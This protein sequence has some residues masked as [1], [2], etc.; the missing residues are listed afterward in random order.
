MKMKHMGKKTAALVLALG[1]TF[2][3]TGCEFFVA[4]NVRDLEQVV[5]TVDISN[6]LATD[7]Q[8]VAA[9]LDTLIADGA[10]STD[11][12]KRELVSL[13]LNS[14]YSYVQQGYSYKDVFNLLMDSLTGRKILALYNPPKRKCL[15]RI[16]KRKNLRK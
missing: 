16:I 6:E 11:I 13:F 3:A 10:I 8:D 12:Y 7:K 15:W 2:G 4:D 1:L 5:A 9:A 14:G